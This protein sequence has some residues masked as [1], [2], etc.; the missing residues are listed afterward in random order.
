MLAGSFFIYI[1]LSSCLRPLTEDR[2]DQIRVTPIDLPMVVYRPE[3]LGHGPMA[4]RANA[5]VD[6]GP[7]EGC[8]SWGEAA[9]SCPLPFPPAKRRIASASFPASQWG[10]GQSSNRIKRIW[11]YLKL[12]NAPILTNN[13]SVQ[14]FQNPPKWPKPGSGVSGQNLISSFDAAF[15][16]SFVCMQMFDTWDYTIH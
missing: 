7:N 6:W 2:W 14:K 12:I 9:A 13:I 4:R 3:N 10:S 16:P 8:G 11:A 1:L 5:P 15:A